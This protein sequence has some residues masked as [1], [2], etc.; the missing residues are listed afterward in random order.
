ML[1]SVLDQVKR[2]RRK[3]PCCSNGEVH[4]KEMQDQF[5]E[6]QNPPEKFLKDLVQAKDKKVRETFL[7]NTMPLNNAFSFASIQSGEPCPP[8]QM[9][10]RM[11]TCK[12]NGNSFLLCFYF[13]TFNILMFRGI[14]VFV[15]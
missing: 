11:D 15:Q 10:G 8:E 12:V 2:G 1:K 4:T 3:T 7:K 6:L 13:C 5:S 9:G 14:F